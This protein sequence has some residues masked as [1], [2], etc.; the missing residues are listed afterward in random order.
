MKESTKEKIHQIEIVA[1]FVLIL[2]SVVSFFP[3][4]GITGY[5]SVE[6]KTQQINLTIAN[7]QS[8]ILT[9]NIQKDFY[10]TSFQLSGEV[11]GDGIVK[12]YLD[13][14]QGQRILIYSNV[15]KKTKGLDSIT[16]MDKITG[17][18]VGTN[19]ETQ[20]EVEE[21]YLVID[22]LENIEEE[23]GE[24]SEDEELAIG[25]FKNKCIDTCFIEM[26]LND[27]IGYQLLFYVEE[28]TILKI[29]E[30]VYS[31]RQD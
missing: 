9:T 25:N 26:L 15:I 30:I 10:L 2:V 16:G 24:I 5:V 22:Y 6:I 8:Y 17:N 14:G 3:N 7:S 1:A 18:V 29:N 21:D 23:L 28:G 4:Q 19:P 20:E 27:E 11:I 13:N 12:A 31:I